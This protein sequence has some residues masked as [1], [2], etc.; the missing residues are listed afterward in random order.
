V[1][2][3]GTLEPDICAD[4]IVHASRVKAARTVASA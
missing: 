2:N 1:V 3:T 4:I